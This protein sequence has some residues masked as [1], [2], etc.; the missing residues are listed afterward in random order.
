[1][2]KDDSLSIPMLIILIGTPIAF[3]SFNWKIAIAVFLVGIVS[4]GWKNRHDGPFPTDK[5]DY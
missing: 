2:K 1:M 4:L 3:F 5:G